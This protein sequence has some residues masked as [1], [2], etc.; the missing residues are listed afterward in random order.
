M[1]TISVSGVSAEMTTISSLE[2]PQSLERSV[3]NT[4]VSVTGVTSVT[5]VSAEIQQSRHWSQC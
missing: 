2:L 1:T 4:T 3:L 5:E